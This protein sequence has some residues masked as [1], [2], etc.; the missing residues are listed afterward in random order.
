MSETNK[1]LARQT[2]VVVQDMPDEVLIYD[3]DLNKA[4]CLNRSAALVWRSCDGNRSVADI[5]K[6]FQAEGVGEVSEDFVWLAVDQLTEKGLLQNEVPPRFRGQ[7]RRQM[8]KTIGLASTVLLPVI[9]SLV[10]PQNALGS[11]SCACTSPGACATRSNC[12]SVTTCN[13]T[14]I[15]APNAAP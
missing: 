6:E 12:P 8:I 14:G 11:I 4:H 7:S 3:L 2:G 9:A 13:T 15:C 10:A 1:P 5:V